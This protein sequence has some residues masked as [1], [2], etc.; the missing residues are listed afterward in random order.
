MEKKGVMHYK[1]NWGLAATTRSYTTADQ[2]KFCPISFPPTRID[3]YQQQ[4]HELMLRAVC[5]TKLLVVKAGTRAEA[6][7]S[8]GKEITPRRRAA[9]IT[10][11]VLGLQYHKIQARTGVATSTANNIYCQAVRNATK[12]ALDRRQH[13]V[14]E[15]VA[16][17]SQAVLSS[18]CNATGV[19]KSEIDIRQV[20]PASFLSQFPAP[21]TTSASELRHL[22]FRAP[23]VET[24]GGASEPRLVEAVQ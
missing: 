22:G 17:G 6:N 20:P 21:L 24:G 12:I 23:D 10:M 11:R 9:I 19:S 7:V 14:S 18:S 4:W 2:N 16:L 8:L 1:C 15:L 3:Y 5:T 13:E